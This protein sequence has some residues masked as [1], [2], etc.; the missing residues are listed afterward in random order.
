MQVRGAAVA[1]SVTVALILVYVP[2][3]SAAISTITSITPKVSLIGEEITITGSGFATTDMVTFSA[4]DFGDRIEAEFTIDSPTQIRATVPGGSTSGNVIIHTADGIASKV[5]FI[6]LQ[7]EIHAFSP[8]KGVPGR[9]IGVQGNNLRVVTS[10]TFNGL[11]ADF[12]IDD[13]GY[14]DAYVPKGAPSGP[15]R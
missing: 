11:D 5:A 7:P 6:A 15:S 10:V 8:V 3:A 2:P 12:S 4:A 14:L 1:A 9:A 13:D